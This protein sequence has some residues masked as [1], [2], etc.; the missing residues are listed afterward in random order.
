MLVFVVS[1]MSKISLSTIIIIIML[2][3]TLFFILVN[4][5]T[6]HEFKSLVISTWFLN[7][8]YKT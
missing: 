7:V 4:G 6:M 1:N 3:S 2:F 8:C 5:K